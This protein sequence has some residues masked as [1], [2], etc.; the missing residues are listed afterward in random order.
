MKVLQKVVDISE[1]GL[2]RTFMVKEGQAELASESEQL[3]EAVDILYCIR[4]GALS[5]GWEGDMTTPSQFR[6]WALD[7]ASK[8]LEKHEYIK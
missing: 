4:Y 5:Q 8:F 3:K 2:E 1:E 6:D 7:E